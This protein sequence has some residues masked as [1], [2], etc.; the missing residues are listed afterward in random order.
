[1]QIPENI[2][3]LIEKYEIGTATT[4]E[5]QA[6][7]E[8]YYSFDDSVANILV[9]GQDSEEKLAERI[10]IR[11]MQTILQSDEIKEAKPMRKFQWSAAAAILI[12]FTVGAYVKFSS[13][14]VFQETTKAPVINNITPGGNKAK[15][16]LHDGTSV[17]LDSV[18]NGTISKQGDVALQKLEDGLLVYNISG[19]KLTEKNE[20][21]YNAISTPRGG[22]YQVTLS[23]GTKVWLNASSSIRFPVIFT[24]DVRSVTITGEAYF[25]VA[26]NTAMPFKVKT[27][28]SEV[29]VLGTH[30]NINSYDDEAVVKTTLLEG[31]VKVASLGNGVLR[32]LKPGQQSIINKEGKISIVEHADTEEAMAWRNGYFQFKS[33]DVK[34]ILRQISRWYDVDIVYNGNIN[35][36]FTGQLTRNENVSKVFEALSLTNEVHFKIDGKKI[37]VSQ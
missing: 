23:D 4:E 31:A 30:F 24:G 27:T 15:L 13:K 21:I 14:P 37:I 9:E 25:E 11:L 18:S 22:Q 26:K 7:K 1:M 36:H 32:Y 28:T 19:K 6:L 12:I 5:K 34:S 10:K 29:E 2:L 17:I 35:L 8:W 16:T 33:S 3:V 20:V